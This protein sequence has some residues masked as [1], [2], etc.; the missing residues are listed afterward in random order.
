MPLILKH[1]LVKP[2]LKKPS[3]ERNVKNY[4]P[5]SNLTFLSKLIESVVISQLTKHLD[6]NDLHDTKQSAYKPN[7][8]TETLLLKVHND[9][10]KGL[11][12]GRVMM[13]VLLDLSAAFDTIDHDILLN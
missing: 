6:D 10:M 7:Y 12:N 1:A 2:Q 9:I 11:S 13:L 8:S 3:L 5:V 4:R